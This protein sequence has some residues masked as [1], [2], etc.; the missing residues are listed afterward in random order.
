MEE[1]GEVTAMT[2][3]EA[4]AEIKTIGKR[5]HKKRESIGSYL[6]RDAR[7]KDP[8]EREGGSVDFIRRE[9]QGIAD[10]ETRVVAIRTAI[11]TVNLSTSLTIQGETRTLAEWLTWRR[12]IAP[13]R[14]HFL[15]TI[16]NGIKQVRDKVTRD[17][18]VVG[19]TEEGSDVVVML[20]E[21]DLHAEI[22]R[23]ELIM[24][25]LDGKLS[26]LNATTTIT[27]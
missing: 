7:M 15:A 8:F 13:G 20:S 19:T 22:E 5:I 6:A 9:R 24:G 17:G 21:K 12:E 18:K 25:E 4:L 27:L 1:G 10:L 26:L 16:A 2:V 11:Q 14:G 23:H 3:T